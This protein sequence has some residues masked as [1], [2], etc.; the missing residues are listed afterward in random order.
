MQPQNADYSQLAPRQK[1]RSDGSFKKG[2][3]EQFYSNYFPLIV[4][5]KISKIYQYDYKLYLPNN[6]EI[7]KDSKLYRKVVKD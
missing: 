1:N 3:N 6:N 5:P 4:S 7:E 2:F